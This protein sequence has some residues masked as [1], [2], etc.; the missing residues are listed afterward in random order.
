[1]ISVPAR[2]LDRLTILE[3]C[4][5]LVRLASPHG[6]DPEHMQTGGDPALVCQLLVERESLFCQRLCPCIELVERQICRDAERLGPQ[7]RR[8]LRTGP[9]SFPQEVSPPTEMPLHGPNL[10]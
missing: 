6:T 4:A 8:C 9:C 3:Q 10:S 5:C 7:A 1:M 2:S